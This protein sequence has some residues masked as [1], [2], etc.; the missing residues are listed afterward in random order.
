MSTGLPDYEEL[1]QDSKVNI[2]LEALINDQAF[3]TEFL[4]TCISNYYVTVLKKHE[5]KQ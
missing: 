3:S 4:A 5:R 2:F 1:L